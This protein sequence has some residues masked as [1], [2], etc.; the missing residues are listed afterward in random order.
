MI[1]VVFSQSN[2]TFKFLAQ[3]YIKLEPDPFKIRFLN[4]LIQNIGSFTTP[5]PLRQTSGVG[6]RIMEDWTRTRHGSLCL[7]WWMVLL[8][9]VQVLPN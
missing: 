4:F 3:N 7:A 9:Q 8:H 1:L 5:V 6:R 2:T